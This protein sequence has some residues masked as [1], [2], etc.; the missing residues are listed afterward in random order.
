MID[1]KDKRVVI[2]GAGG[3]VGR[4]LCRAFGAAGATLVGC[5]ADRSQVPDIC[6]TAHG[7]DLRDDDAIASKRDETPSPP[8]PRALVLPTRVLHTAR[9]ARVQPGRH[10][11]C[12]L[13][14]L[15]HV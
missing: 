10:A 1:L 15:Y 6:E 14:S 11:L 9:A 12:Q 7:F 2:T 4:A 5:D 3:G 13:S 8:R